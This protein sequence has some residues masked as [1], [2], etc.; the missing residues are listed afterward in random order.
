MLCADEVVYSSQTRGVAPL[1]DFIANKT[2]LHGFS[3]AD[4]VVGKAAALLY[5]LLGVQAVYAPVMSEAAV[6][7]FEKHN[8]QAHYD[9]V[10]KG[11]RN[12]EN[13]G[14]CP[15][16]SAVESI[17]DPKE[18]LLAIQNKLAQMKKARS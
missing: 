4:K 16:E 12:R 1:L 2:D 13:T 6:A 18:A 5:V 11:I 3:A 17:F 9:T 14:M 15:M 7:V 8:I 10:A